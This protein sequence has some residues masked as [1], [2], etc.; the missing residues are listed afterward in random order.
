METVFPTI[1]TDAQLA[2]VPFAPL[3]MPSQLQVP[4]IITE[5]ASDVEGD[6]ESA[7]Q[8]ARALQA[9]LS[10]EGFFSHGLEGEVL[11]PSGHG[12]GRILALFGGD[13]MI[14]DDEQYAVAMTLM[15]RQLGMPARVVMGW[16]AD[17]EART[18]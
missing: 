6:A 8:R 13:Q 4:P 2:N 9:W 14:G 12:A 10:A 1:P 15:A 7:I 18:R 17:L 16:H 3:K 5:I 11:S